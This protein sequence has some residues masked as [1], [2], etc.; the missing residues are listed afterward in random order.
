MTNLCFMFQNRLVIYPFIIV[1]MVFSNIVFIDECRA[2]KPTK[3]DSLAEV[4]VMARR[5]M[6]EIGLQKTKID[7]V[8]LHDNIS[9]SMA[10]ILAFNSSLFMKESGRASLAT[11]S[12]RGTSPSHTQVTWNGMR[13]NNP[14][15]GTTDFS[16]IPA[17]FIDKADLLHGSAS[18]NESGGGL[19]GMVKLTSA[20]PIHEGFHL[21]YVQGIG[22]FKTFD[23]FLKFSYAHKHWSCATR[24][25]FS[26]SAN[27]YKY[28][29][30][31]KKIYVNNQ[32][33]IGH[34]PVERNKSGSFKDFHIMQEMNYRNKANVAGLCVWYFSSNREMPLLTTDYGSERSFDNRQRENT[35]RSVL[36]WNH[37]KPLWNLNAK[38]GYTHTWIAYDYKR[39]MAYNLWSQMTKSRSK[40]NTLFLSCEGDCTPSSKWY[41]TFNSSLYQH[42]VLSADKNIIKVDGNKVVVGYDRA[43]I[44]W[45]SSVSA[46]WQP[47]KRLGISGVVRKELYGEK[48]TPL[49]PALY[50]DF[51]LSR[52]IDLTVKG[53]ISR[54]YHF[55]SLNDMYFMP[56]GNPDLNSERGWGYDVS[57]QYKCR[58]DSTWGINIESCWF[59]SHIKDWIIWLPTTKGYFTPQNVKSVHTYGI[60]GKFKTFVKLPLHWRLDFLGSYAWTPSINEG[61]KMSEADQSVGKQLP[62]TPRHTITFVGRLSWQEWE[63]LYKWC[64]YSER[65]TTS[66]EELSITGKLP[67]YYMSNISIGKSFKIKKTVLSVKAAINNLFNED[68]VSVL[69]HPMPGINYEVFVSYSPM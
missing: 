29:N 17:Y 12:M 6:K 43:R 68:Y 20:S 60:E 9:L 11:V 35:I 25:V 14:M 65:F 38:G 34:H 27:N 41:F 24:I 54:N 22:P 23:E 55:P 18:V 40:V 8:A 42:F 56:G 13:V 3:T 50:S 48:W 62:Y 64:H 67:R 44:E 51:L 1:Y 59:D 15:V 10:D 26:S 45:S 28:T 32:D 57:L 52:K 19:G 39:E 61:E 31:D 58:K 49:I 36:S 16:T 63:F 37:T 30:H 5:S 66:S 33:T 47:T 2:Q 21:Q 53:S 7:T 69:S 46:K 4:V